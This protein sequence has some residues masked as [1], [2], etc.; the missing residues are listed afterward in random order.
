MKNILRLL[1]ATAS[2]AILAACGG[3]GGV[4]GDTTRLSEVQRNY[5]ASSV[6]NSYNGFSWYLPTDASS[7]VSGTNFFVAT[8]VA[9][10][11]SPE[12]GP[13]TISSGLT[14]M[15]ATLALPDAT[16]L[17]VIRVLL[18]GV[19]YASNFTSRA[20]ASFVGDAV[21]LQPY[22]VD[23]QTKLPAQDFDYWSEPIIL[24][25]QLA[26]SEILKKYYRFSTTTRLNN[27]DMSKSWQAGSSYVVRKKLFVDEAVEVSD[28]NTR[29]Y[30]ENVTPW[31][32]SQSTIED[33]F[34]YVTM[35][36][37]GVTWNGTTYQLA[38]GEITS[39]QGVRMWISNNKNPASSSPTDSYTCIF[40]LNGKIYFGRYIAA[41]TRE[42]IINQL[43]TTVV[44]DSSI[45]FNAIAVQSIRD[46]VK[47]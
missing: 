45:R 38:D 18:N 46:A 37:G 10:S 30:D 43:D 33:M 7:P 28:W 42:K 40:E 11:A 4:G 2:V 25:G 13:Q 36:F 26:Q 35:N 19:I 14:N 41:G 17:S 22:A 23:D 6:A 31:S 1:L 5:I 32:G 8:T 9:L 20:D 12:V 16:K 44:L 27:L 34:S 3:G 24:T 29:T 47:F 21:R 39:K 15:A